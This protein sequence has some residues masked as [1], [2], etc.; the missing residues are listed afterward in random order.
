MNWMDCTADGCQIHLSKK[1]GSAW[2][3][4]FNKRSKQPNVAHNHDWRQEIEANQG[5][6]W[7]PQQRRQRRARRAHHQITS[8][9]HFFNDKCNDNRLEKV[10]P[11]YYPQ[12]VG[13]KGRLS[14]KD[15]KELKKRNTVRTRRGREGSEKTIPDVEAM[16]GQISDLRSQLNRATQIIVAKDNDLERLDKEK[17]KLPQPYN[18]GKQSS[19]QIGGTR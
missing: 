18:L 16:E 10:D 15:T 17:E 9:E 6:D 3:P 11:G 13:E 2:Y 5:E 4:Q 7:A 12:Q 1:Q 8:W 14:G 19:R